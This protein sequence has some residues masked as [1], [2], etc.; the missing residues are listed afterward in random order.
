MQN[1]SW[2]DIQ[3]GLVVTATWGSMRF[4]DLRKCCRGSDL[5]MLQ[6]IGSYF[7]NEIDWIVAE[8]DT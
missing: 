6:V 5:S 8:L 3:Q 1:D 2:F 4:T 7:I